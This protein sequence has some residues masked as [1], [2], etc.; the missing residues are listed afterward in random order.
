MTG[1]THVACGVTLMI[2]VTVQYTSGL[3]VSG[4][5][6]DPAVGLSTVAI[7]SYLADIDIQRSKMGQ[8]YKLISRM[9]THRG[10]THTLLFPA[11]LYVAIITLA[12]MPVIPSLL[13]GLLVGWVSHL[14]A[15]ICNK[16][17][18]PILWPIT[19]K[20]LHIA[21]FKT[22][23]WQEGVFL[24]IWIGGLFVCLKTF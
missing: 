22:G 11:L 13:F 1:K 3:D 12:T 14:M 21:T 23:T 15:D 7:G 6:I 5:H 8:K 20:K 10:I 24:L 18:I 17:G 4:I 19:S 9:L 2:A 16:K